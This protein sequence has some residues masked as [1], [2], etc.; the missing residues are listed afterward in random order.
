MVIDTIY[1]DFIPST[2]QIRQFSSRH[3]G[4]GFDQLL[5]LSPA[6]HHDHDYFYQI[7]NADGSEVGQCGNGA[8]C[9]FRYIQAYLNPQAKKIKLATHNTTLELAESSNQL[10]KMTLPAPHFMPKDIPINSDTAHDSYELNPTLQVHALSVGNPHAIYITPEPLWTMEIASLGLAIS[11]HPLF[12]E[13]ANANFVQL[14]SKQQISLR[15]FE[16]GVGETLA[17]GSGALAS[18]IAG[19]RFHGLNDKVLVKLKGGDLE[20]YWPNQ[21]GPI[22]QYGPAVE[23]FRAQLCCD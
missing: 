19:M 1:H 11:Q 10:I 23:V 18:A 9:A 21:Q 5:I 16:R 13:Q 15:V 4:V 14:D 17:C 12:P 22:Y 20:V 8:R 3:F 2:A 7:F 6:K